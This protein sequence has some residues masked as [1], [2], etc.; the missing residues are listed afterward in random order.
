MRTVESDEISSAAG[1]FAP[2]P[3]TLVGGGAAHT[4]GRT[5]N[6]DRL[7]NAFAVAEIGR[8]KISRYN[9]RGQRKF[10]LVCQFVTEQRRRRP[11]GK[12]A[13]TR[14][15][16]PMRRAR[17]MPSPASRSGR[18]GTNRRIRGRERTTGSAPHLV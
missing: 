8:A 18:G 11:N 5:S 17:L 3:P 6:P 13:R 4:T 12:C 15:A 9:L 7:H 2:I 14:S 16:T 1:G 10:P